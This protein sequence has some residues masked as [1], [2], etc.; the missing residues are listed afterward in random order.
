[1]FFDLHCGNSSTPKKVGGQN[2]GRPLH[3]KNR[4]DMFPCPPTDLRPWSYSVIVHW[5]SGVSQNLH[6]HRSK[7][8]RIVTLLNYSI[9]SAFRPALETTFLS[10]LCPRTQ[11]P[12]TVAYIYIDDYHQV[13]IYS[14]RKTRERLIAQKLNDIYRHF[15]SLWWL[16]V[17]SL[18][19]ITWAIL[20]CIITGS[21]YA[22][23]KGSKCIINIVILLN[24]IIGAPAT[25][26]RK[27]IYADDICL[28]TQA[29]YFS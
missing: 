10:P 12:S 17:I 6:N 21:V 9:L 13:D 24:I 15:S 16:C 5:H 20:A 1:M 19:F 14:A 11:P 8:N 26:G 27:F 25:Q 29:Q 3:F 4:G 2:T 7:E 23:L 18:L 28:A 22:I